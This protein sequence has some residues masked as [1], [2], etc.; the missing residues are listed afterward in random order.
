MGE[1]S[2][3]QNP[4]T[5]YAKEQGWLARRMQYIGTNGCP[6][7]W[8]FKDGRV[9]ICEWKR[10][11]KD[12]TLQQKRQHKKLRAAGMTVHVIDNYEDGCALFD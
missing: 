2:D 11:G 1:I 12:A 6:D 5:Q 8:F 4:V 10:D 7:T 3:V 9:I